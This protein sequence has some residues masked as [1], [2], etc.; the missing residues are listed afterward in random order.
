MYVFFLTS[1]NRPPKIHRAASTFIPPLLTP[2]QDPAAARALVSA[3][4][5]LP[6]SAREQSSSKDDEQDDD[7]DLKRAKDLVELHYGVKEASRK[8]E[9]E[10]GLREAREMVDRAVGAV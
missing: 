1:P 6:T 2:L 3:S 7:E 8:G 10:R 4:A 9:L 5:T